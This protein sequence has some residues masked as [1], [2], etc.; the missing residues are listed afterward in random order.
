M[1][2][3]GNNKLGILSQHDIQSKSVSLTTNV[4]STCLC[5]AAKNQTTQK[6][7]DNNNNNEINQVKKKY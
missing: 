1:F 5:T 2:L 6:Y 4:Q 7:C 3:A